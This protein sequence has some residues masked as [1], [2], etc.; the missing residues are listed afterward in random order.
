MKRYNKLFLPCMALMLATSLSSCWHENLD[1]CWKG[2]VILSVTAER[3]QQAPDAP[4]VENMASCIDNMQYYLFDSETGAFRGSGLVSGSEIAGDH[5]DLTLGVLPFGTYT[6]ALTANAGSV[7]ENVD[8]WQ[9]VSLDFLENVDNDCFASLYQ[10]TLDCECG[11]T[12]FVKLY[13]TKG[14]VEVKLNRLPETIVRAE[15]EVNNVSAVCLPDTTYQGTTEMSTGKAVTD[16]SGERNVL[17]SMF[18]FPTATDAVSE[19][20]LT[21]YM[22]GHDGE[23]I[24]ALHRKLNETVS[25]LRNQT[26]GVEVDFNNSLT[27]Q[28]VVGITINPE[29]DGVSDDTIVDFD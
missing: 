2:N 5:Y 20:T 24:V 14:E 1:D 29:W 4:S 27:S 25:V 23:E 18:A 22:T 19:I 7:K 11:Y 9:S 12:D 21:L 15:V 6:V 13:R 26:V 16:G 3:F 28:P 8:S 17:L 10:F